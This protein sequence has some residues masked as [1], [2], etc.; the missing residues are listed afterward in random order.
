M[1]GEDLPH[2]TNFTEALR[3]CR[4]HDSEI[5]PLQSIFRS[6]KED[7]EGG[8]VFNVDLRISGEGFGDFVV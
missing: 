3:K 6:A 1:F 2:Y 7:F 4:G 8:Y 5:R